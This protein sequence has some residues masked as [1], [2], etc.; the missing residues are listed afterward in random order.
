MTKRI[1][2]RWIVA[3][4]VC[5]AA[6]APGRADDPADNDEGELIVPLR[7]DDPEE[8][9]LHKRYM[10]QLFLSRIFRQAGLPNMLLKPDDLREGF[11]DRTLHKLDDLLRDSRA[12]MRAHLG[13]VVDEPLKSGLADYDR[14]DAD[15]GRLLRLLALT[16]RQKIQIRKHINAYRDTTRGLGNRREDYARRQ[17][18]RID[19]AR[20]VAAELSPAQNALL[21]RLQPAHGALPY[22]VKGHTAELAR[23]AWNRRYR[24]VML[25][26][27]DLAER[28]LTFVDT[29]DA[30][31]VSLLPHGGVVRD[32]Q[33]AR[34]E[35]LAAGEPVLCTW[36]LKEDMADLVV[37]ARRPL[38]IVTGR[39]KKAAAGRLTLEGAIVEHVALKPDTP[40]IRPR[41]ATPGDDAAQKDDAPL[42][43]R[44]VTVVAA[45]ALERAEAVALVDHGTD[46]VA[47]GT[48][49]GTMLSVKATS[50]ML[51][52]YPGVRLV[53]RRGERGSVTVP[54]DVGVTILEG[55]HYVR[56]TLED[57]ARKVR[58][59]PW[60]A[61]LES[62]RG[63]GDAGPIEF[64]RLYE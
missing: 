38:V 58:E 2:W 8:R 39:V 28:R 16:E 35:D 5:L 43:G 46:G 19:L 15:F 33:P 42:A 44:Y 17:K 20:T 45:G 50:E 63:E 62:P 48:V 41:R 6:A 23:N 27:V 24:S 18:A 26:G 47:G 64:I 34:L 10:H 55:R 61:T 60:R 1:R 12:R 40:R 56:A 9:L 7:L 57:L 30:Q 25:T 36:S 3:L 54:Q 14:T 49:R 13:K 22:I 51:F 21:T 53:A 32:G 37:Q 52:Y 11:S 4:A 31:T 29:I 59:R